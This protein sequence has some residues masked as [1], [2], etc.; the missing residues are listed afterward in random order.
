M[1]KVIG[2]HRPGSVG[3]AL[4]L[5]AGDGNAPRIVMGGG[6]VINGNRSGDPVEIVDLQSAG[7]ASI[8]DSDGGLV[9]GA[10][11]TLQ[12]LADHPSTPPLVADLARREL[13]STLRTLGTVG[14]LVAKAEADSELLAALLAFGATVEVASGDGTAR[15]DLG[16]VLRDGPGG[17]IA[18]IRIPTGGRAI[19]ARTG[20]TPGD[21]P[22][23]AAVAHRSEDGDVRL[24]MSGVASIP[25]LVD[26]QSPIDPPADFRGS[27]EYRRRIATVLAARV[28]RETR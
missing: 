15:R 25:V 8:D 11:V 26:D 2:Y 28:T 10:T 16:D 27:S 9:V 12:A 23:V 7:L 17:I 13:P 3:E 4:A 19:A 22:I 14:G 5:L 1:P 21:R 20:R 24:A 6:T 18:S